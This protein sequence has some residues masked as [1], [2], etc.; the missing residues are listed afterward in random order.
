MATCVPSNTLRRSRWRAGRVNALTPR[1]NQ[2]VYTPRSPIGYSR[3]TEVH[4]GRRALCDSKASS[5]RETLLDG[6]EGRSST[7]YLIH[8]R[9]RSAAVL[10]DGYDVV[11]VVEVPV[12][13]RDRDPS[14][15]V[16]PVQSATRRRKLRCDGVFIG[17]AQEGGGEILF[18][19]SIPLPAAG[20][21]VA[22]PPIPPPSLAESIA[23][24]PTRRGGRTVGIDHLARILAPTPFYNNSRIGSRSVKMCCGLPLKSA[25]ISRVS[26][27]RTR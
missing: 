6:A 4:Y 8:A 18:V 24:A 11:E 21:G 2:G 5:C 16:R 27:P 20:G 17:V 26:T 10:R 3:N 25:I 1:P 19:E 14:G 7:R 22:V 12:G 23:A 13:G 15:R 9:A